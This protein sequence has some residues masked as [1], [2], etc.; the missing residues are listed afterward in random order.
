MRSTF[1]GL[2]Q[3]RDTTWRNLPQYMQEMHRQVAYQENDDDGDQH[4][5]GLPSG[6]QLRLGGRRS[7]VQHRF[8][9][10]KNI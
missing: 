1:I 5:G 4:Y 2:H 6:L 10:C 7:T 9:S 3:S 8:A